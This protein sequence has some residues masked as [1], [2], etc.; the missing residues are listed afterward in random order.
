M[1]F[2]D[3]KEHDNDKNPSREGG[4]Y[5]NQSDARLDPSREGGGG[6]NAG[7]REAVHH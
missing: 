7:R 3:A 6:R 4:S 1:A 2:D 5:L